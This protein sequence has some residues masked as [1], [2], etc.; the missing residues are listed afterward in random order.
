MTVRDTSLDAYDRIREAGV[1]GA[2][3]ERIA[4][5]LFDR[6]PMTRQEIARQT[7]LAINAVCGRVNELIKSAH[8]VELEKRPCR[9]SGHSAHPVA[10]RRSPPIQRALG[11]TS[12]DYSA[13]TGG[14]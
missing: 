7:G 9:T 3:R 5:Y 2:Q 14:E 1:T 12:A 6:D 4:A 10:W 13:A 8:L 11:F